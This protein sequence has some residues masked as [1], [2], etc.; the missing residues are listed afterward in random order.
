MSIELSKGIIEF[1]LNLENLPICTFAS[2]TVV[3]SN[4]FHKLP[5]LVGIDITLQAYIL[6]PYYKTHNHI[7]FREEKISGPVLTL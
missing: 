2:Q 1:G 5:P 6:N 3:T 4:V 7:V